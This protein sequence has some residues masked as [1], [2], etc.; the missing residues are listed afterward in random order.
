MLAYACHPTNGSEPHLGWNAVKQLAKNFSVTCLVTGNV[1]GQR[2]ALESVEL[3]N[4]T[5]VY[6]ELPPFLEKR[7][8]TESHD[9]RYYLTQFFWRK[10]V[11]EL[12]K[13][14]RFDAAI[15]ATYARYWM[16]SALAAIDIPKVFGPVGGGEKCPKGL[17]Q[18]HSFKNMISEALRYFIPEIVQFDPFF[19]YNIETWD[20]ALGTTDESSKELKN[21]GFPN[22]STRENIGVDLNELKKNLVDITESTSQTVNFV[23]IARILHWKGIQYALQ[24]M[25]KMDPKGWTYQIAG[26]GP[27][28]NKLKKIVANNKLKNVT[29]LGRIKRTEALAMIKNSDAL[30]HPSLHD[31]GSFVVQEAM[32]L[33]TFAIY[34]QCGGPHHLCSGKFGYGVKTDNTKILVNDLK[35]IL[36]RIVKNPKRFKKLSQNGSKIV[37]ENYTWDRYG[38]D[39]HIL[40]NRAISQRKIA[41]QAMI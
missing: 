31:S 2:E 8:D 21:L 22:V 33:N 11:K 10:K 34:L 20:Y 25:S 41:K 29:F 16:P 15:H 3:E 38:V 27:Y 17:L 6:A 7:I 4:V 24:A 39:M 37:A 40:L 18:D 9:I 5:F 35:S 23:S 36:E 19:K 12:H 32:A 1:E 28:I 13:K 26:N 14:H 30:I